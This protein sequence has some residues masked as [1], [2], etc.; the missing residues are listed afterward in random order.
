MLRYLVVFSFLLYSGAQCAMKDYFKPALNKGS[1]HKMPGIDFIYMIN[2]DQRPEKFEKASAQ[3]H[4]Y[5]IKPYRF[6]AVNGWELSLEAINELGVK[7]RPGMTGGF[8]G[9]S[10][11]SLEEG[12]HSVI[13]KYG[14]TYYC[15]CMARGPIGILLSH[16]S[17][18]KDALKSNYQ[19]IWVMEDDIEVIRN[20]KRIS[21]MISELDRLVGNGNWDVLFTDRD[22]KDGKG[23]YVP[24]TSMARR[25]NYLEKDLMRFSRRTMI[26][27]DLRRIGARFGAYSMILRRSGIEKIYNFIRDHRLFLPYDMDY[28]LPAGIKLYTVMEDIVS[29]L[30]NAISDNGVPNYL[31]KKKPN[32]H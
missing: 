23:K 32:L 3:L 5:G 25:P 15:H 13:S 7:F 27:K 26:S 30:P 10:Y 21:R 1:N 2:L 18:L 16:L 24:C 22:T 28:I 14:R 17:I 29:T 9:T 11:P 8:M 4:P 12:K 19:T 20:P 31:K 6:S